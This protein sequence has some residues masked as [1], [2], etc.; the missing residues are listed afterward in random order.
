LDDVLLFD[1][2]YLLNQEEGLQV[3]DDEGEGD[4]KEYDPEERRHMV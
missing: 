1:P 3:E 2:D 4:E